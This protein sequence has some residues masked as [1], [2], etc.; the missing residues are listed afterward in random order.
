M[1]PEATY[2]I[3]RRVLRDGRVDAEVVFAE[4]DQPGTMHFGVVEEEDGRPLAIA[5]VVPMDCPVRPAR[6]AWRV[7]GMAVDPAQRGRG[8][9]GRLLE[10]IETRA[11]ADGVEV[12]WADGRDAALAF[13][14]RHGW[15]VVGEGYLTADTGLPHHRIIFDLKPRS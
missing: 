3:R 12:L 5:S 10:E 6:T 1:A 8:L 13:Y 7:R 9:G 11:V 14:R 15:T 4:D 2:D